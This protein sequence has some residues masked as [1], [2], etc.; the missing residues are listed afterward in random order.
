M[1]AAALLRRFGT[2]EN[3]FLA[4]AE[5]YKEIDGIRRS[6]ISQ[7]Q[8]KDIEIA[9]KTLASCA[10]IGCR[11]ITL[12]DAEY[13]ER[14]RNIYDPPIALY[15]RG[16]LPPIDDEP[17]VAIVGTR[18]CTPYG[19]KMAENIGYRLAHHNLLVVTG[20]ARG[21]DTAAARGALRGGGPV[22]GVIGS[23]LDVI[24]PPENKTLFDDVAS[25][26]A[27]IS[28]YPPGAAAI[29]SHFPVRNRILSGISLG[30]AVI[31]A[32]KKSGA[33]IT[34]ARALEQG[35]DVFALPGNVDAR[36]SEGSNLL[37]REG[38]IPILSGEDI[39]GEY[40]ELFPERIKS[41]SQVQMIPLE[42]KGTDRAQ[43][44]QLISD[45]D[46]VTAKHDKNE[47][48]NAPEVEYINL[49][50]ILNAL[51]GDEKIVAETIG[52]KSMPVDEIIIGSGLLTPQVLTALTMLEINGY[53]MRN[54][55]MYELRGLFNGK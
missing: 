2:P 43:K 10:E 12:Q 29:A 22:I 21:I 17:A 39:V 4:G 50:E 37:L 15:V 25:S 49:D 13:P 5:D 16:N 19:L 42:R 9:N 3:V 33:L 38:A 20:L 53:A 51:T 8:I 11:V 7:L 35:R 18:T 6:D 44:A 24:Y 40:A 36:N 30:V 23:G 48:D 55:T 52:T 26:G 54:S 45:G 1:T 32:P 41:N 47:I 31:E 34:A 27:I 14:L 46:A 28:E